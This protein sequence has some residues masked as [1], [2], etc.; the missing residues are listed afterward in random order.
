[1]LDA[2]EARPDS[3]ERRLQTL[4]EA[5][6]VIVSEL[7][8]DELLR[9]VVISARRIVG[10][11]Y[12]ALG[13]VGRNGLLEQFIHSGM[14]EDT[15]T[16][17]GELPKGRGLLGA[18]LDRPEPIRLGS[19][20]DDPRSSGVPEGHPPMGPFLGVPIRSSSSVYGNL[21]LANPVGQHEFDNEDQHLVTALAATAGV[22]IENARL[23]AQ[24]QRRQ[25]WLRATTEVS[26]RLLASA[27]DHTVLAEIACSVRRLTEADAV[28]ILLPAPDDPSHL[29]MEVVDGPGTGGLQGL[30]IPAAGGQVHQVIESERSQVLL[31]F[32]RRLAEIS[33]L[34]AYPPIRHLMA[35][36]LHG[37]GR[38]GGAVVA[39]RLTDE[40]FSPADLEMADGFASQAGLA[41]GLAQSRRTRHQLLML[42]D[43]ARIARELHDHVVQKL[44]AAGLTLQGTATMVGDADLR[45]R[46]TAAIDTLDDTIRMI[47]TSIF[48]LQEPTLPGSSVRT[49]VM[50]VLGEM[51]PVLGFAPQLRMEGP[52]DTMVDEALGSEVEAVLRESLTNAAKHANASAVT[53]GLSTEGRTLVMTVA[54]DGVGLRR[55]ARRSGLSNLRHRAESRGGRLDLERA[56]EGGLLLRWSIPLPG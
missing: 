29:V 54:D 22:A 47:R 15:V 3:P 23:H 6:A 7:S 24:S 38:P 43:R 9:R 52:L 13:V 49:R 53:V 19:L 56:P 25:Q 37:G 55:S 14:D 30:R 42:D 16:A 39:C 36:P 26:H 48:E 28:G 27:D 10:A 17:I 2:T 4:I 50:G 11:R 12:A 40:P 31:D 20:A 35:L 34:H 8:L 32:E 33:E 5:N 51:T 45:R 1:V 44:F 41:L 21:Y 46:L 18:L